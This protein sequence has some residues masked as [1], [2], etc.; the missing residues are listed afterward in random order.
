MT[1]PP[2]RRWS[3]FDIDFSHREWSFLPTMLSR[4][5]FVRNPNHYFRSSLSTFSLLHSPSCCFSLLHSISTFSLLLAASFSFSM[6]SFA[7]SSLHSS[8][9]CFSLLHSPSRCIL[10]LV[11]PFIRLLAASRC[12]ILLLDA[13]FRWF[14]PS[15]VFSLLLAA[16]FAF[17]MHSFAGSSLHSP[18][19]RC[20]SSFRPSI[21]AFYWSFGWFVCSLV[22][23]NGLSDDLS[24]HLASFRCCDH[25]LCFFWWFDHAFCR[26]SIA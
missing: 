1:Y 9:C 15:F 23:P 26:Y 22:R 12:F 6:H 25:L 18:S 4:C 21:T 7:G 16:S 3:F 19:S 5:W 8:S 2:R 17:S 13:F 14:V 10:S 20:E 24:L 11:R